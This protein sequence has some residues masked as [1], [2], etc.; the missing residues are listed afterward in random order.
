M[1]DS[2]D[3][4]PMIPGGS[5]FGFPC[6]WVVMLVLASIL[7]GCVTRQPSREPVNLTEAKQAVL[8][9][10][11]SGSYDR[12]TAEVAALAGSWIR[13]RAA[14]TKP[15]ERLVVVFDIDETVLSNLPHMR[16]QDFGYVPDLWNVW[17][18]KGTAAAIPSFR[19]VYDEAIRLGV[20]VVFVTGRRDP[21]D[22]PGTER[23]LRAEG[24]G[25]YLRLV[26]SQ[27]ADKGVPTAERK[28]RARAALEREGYVV[29]ASIGDQWSDLQGG[30]AER[31]FKIPNPFYL[32][33]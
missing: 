2:E 5:S 13:Q 24:M 7:A 23:N 32:I 33:P 12:E 20:Q 9:Y 10:V 1:D 18:D 8:S 28:R 15:G 22:R 19:G 29:I 21:A 30:H 25:T 4:H 31:V 16:E 3:E 26:L 17:V 14:R 11:E 27:A 6:R